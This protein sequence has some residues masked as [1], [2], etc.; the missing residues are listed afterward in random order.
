MVS[1]VKHGQTYIVKGL[2][3]LFGMLFESTLSLTVIATYTLWHMHT[4]IREVIAPF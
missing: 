3:G 1:E 4:H 2:L